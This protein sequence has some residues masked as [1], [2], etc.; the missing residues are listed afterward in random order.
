MGAAP[1]QW[2]PGSGEW[3]LLV[4]WGLLSIPHMRRDLSLC[5]WGSGLGRDTILHCAVLMCATTTAGPGLCLPVPRPLLVWAVLWA[6]PFWAVRGCCA[7]MAAVSCE[8]EGFGGVQDV[9]AWQLLVGQQH[10]KGKALADL[11]ASVQPLAQVAQGV[12]PAQ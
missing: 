3:V 2:T 10:S 5:R 12:C 6:L 11:E 9:M 8:A 7:W 1:C 4:L